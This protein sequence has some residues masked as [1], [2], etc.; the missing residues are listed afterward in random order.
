MTDEERLERG[1]QVFKKVYGDV[2]EL[3]QP[4]EPNSFAGLTMKNLFNDIWGREGL[5]MRD[6][7]LVI[8]G[9]IAGLGADPTLFDIH[10]RSAMGNGELTADELR[11]IILIALPYVGYPRTSPL[12]MVV[13]KCIA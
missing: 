7:R 12:H 11:E 8:L 2:L 13:E 5:S 3:P 4:I 1:L 6:R 10:I 9:A